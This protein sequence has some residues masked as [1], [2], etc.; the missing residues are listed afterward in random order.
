MCDMFATFPQPWSPPMR[1][2]MLSAILLLSAVA[3]GGSSGDS[4]TGNNPG[5]GSGPLSA[6]I[7]GKAWAS[8]VPAA[9]FKNNIVSI[10]GL[11]AALTTTVSFAFGATGT[12]T[13][14]LAPSNSVGGLGLVVKTSGTTS[15]SWGTAL[16]GGSGS[17]TLT[18]LTA[19]H[20]VGTFAFDAV[21]SSAGATGTVHVTNGKFDIT[22]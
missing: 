18:T 4:I 1:R 19:N 8:V 22:F 5:T 17:V 9:I 10:A 12:G 13:Y 6:T 15:Q 14:S 2:T 20:V 21:P 3:C 7:D 11:D 16:S